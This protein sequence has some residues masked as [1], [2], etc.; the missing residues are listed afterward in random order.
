MCMFALSL[1]AAEV[2]APGVV[3]GITGCVADC[4][5]ELGRLSFAVCLDVALGCCVV[6]AGWGTAPLL[7]MSAGLAG[8]Q[9]RSMPSVYR[10]VKCGVRHEFA[11]DLVFCRYFNHLYTTTPPCTLRRAFLHESCLLQQ[12]LLHQSAWLVF[13]E[14]SASSPGRI[15]RE[16]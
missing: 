16:A 13:V 8:L 7:N 14:Q 5:V 9:K 2:E 1:T 15:S 12:P 4:I 6:A 10:R 3:G 11:F